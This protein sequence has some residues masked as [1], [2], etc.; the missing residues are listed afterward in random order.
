MAGAP[1]RTRVVVIGAGFGGIGLGIKLKQS[2]L[3][4]FVILEKSD[5]AGGVWRDNDYPGAACDVPSH[6]YSFSFEPRADWPDKY[7][8]QADILEYLER[9]V[10]KHGLQSHIR[11]R[12]QVTEARWDDASGH[13]TVSTAGG[14]VYQAQAVVTAT[15]QLSRPLRPA[16][17]GLERFSG[18]VFHSAE[19]RHDYDMRGKRIAVIGTGASAIQFIPAI[20]PL[21]E[22]LVV[23]QRSAPYVLPK[24]DKAYPRWQRF[25]FERVPGALRLS[26]ALTYLSHEVFAFAFVFWPAALRIKRG[27]FF[28]H[29][30]AGVKDPERRR[31]LHPHYRIGCKRILLSNDFYPAMDR[32]NVELVTQ[33]IKEVTPRTVITADGAEHEADCIV[34]G[35][36]FTATD[37]LVPIKIIG[38]GGADLHQAWRA[39]AEAHLGI[40]VAGFPNFFMLFGPNTNL[41][42]NSIVYMLECQIRYVTACLRRLTRGE[43]RTLEIRPDAQQRSNAWVR[44]RLK[45]TVWGKGCSSWYLTAEGRNTTN[46]PGYTL[47]FW[48][49][50]RAPRWDDYVAR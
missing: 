22:K 41:A 49:K 31:G 26:R 8:S 45:R 15:G 30:A 21:V 40:T 27:A 32:P 17:P 2:G 9:C 46:W 44:R 10:R 23:F 6:L 28:R 39:G 38:S 11:F 42:H 16:L 43:L 35:T 3:D 47:E 29:L 33:A 1:M 48:L 19:W 18:T 14:G 4:D 25:L 12:Q 20:A 37:F 34:F 13:W 50:T 5:S 24:P 36:G 7:A